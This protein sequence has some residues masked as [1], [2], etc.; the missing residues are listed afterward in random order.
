MF[1]SPAVWDTTAYTDAQWQALPGIQVFPYGEKKATRRH[2]FKEMAVKNQYQWQ[3][4]SGITYG[5][6]VNQLSIGT[7]GIRINT[8]AITQERVLGTIVVRHYLTFRSLYPRAVAADPLR[9]AQEIAEEHP[10]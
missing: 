8:A 2:T 10:Q 1:D 5:A 6:D 4:T 7:T 9:I 3:P